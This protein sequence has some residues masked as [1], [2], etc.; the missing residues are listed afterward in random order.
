MATLKEALAD[1][2]DDRLSA[3]EAVDRH[4]APTFRQRTNGTW[5]DRT[6]FVARV[7]ALRAAV[8]RIELTVLDELTDDHRY[9]E[10][11]IVAVVRRDGTRAAHE[12]F[13][14]AERASDGRFVRLEET[15]LKVDVEVSRA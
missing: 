10:R 11:H 5:D 3:E 9:A 1:L 4:F 2:F 13:A 8:E 7:A 14:F 6:A 15:T 12:V